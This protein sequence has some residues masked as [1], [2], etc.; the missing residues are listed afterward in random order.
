MKVR[1]RWPRFPLGE[2]RRVYGYFGGHLRE[3]R[4]A[5]LGGAACLMGIALVEM[6][7]PW[8]LKL[9]FDH[10]L[11]PQQAHVGWGGTALRD[12]ST[13]QILILAS[14]GLLAIAVISGLLTYGQ[15]MLLGAVGHRVV[16][17]IRLQLFSHIQRLPQSYHDQRE[18]GDLM[19]RLTG[20]LNLLKDLLVSIVIT[21]GSRIV[22][23]VGMLVAMLWM[24]WQ[25]TLI[26]LSI[27]PVLLAA[28]THFS[29]RIKSESRR[30]RRKEGMLADAV[31]QSFAGMTL[32][33]VFAQEKRQEKRFSKGIS[34]DV[35]A[36]LKI[37]RLEASFSRTVEI[38]TALGLCLV[39]WF[40]VRRV[41]AQELSAGD[42]LIFMSY[43]RQLYRPVRDTARLATRTSKAIVAA[44]RVMEVLDLKAPIEDHPG[45]VSA[46]G[47]QGATRFEGVT[48]AYSAGNPVLH[49]VSFAIPAGKT[50][51]IIGPSGS[52]KSTI[53]KL[54]LRLYEPQTGRILIDERDY[55]EYQLHSF[56]KQITSLTQDVTMF[57]ASVR[58]NIAFSWPKATDDQ[59]V[60]AAQSVGAHQFIMD[61]PNGYDTVLG[62]GGLT[63][64]GGQR[65]RLA[66]ARAALRDSRI[67]IFDEPATGLDADA[68]R[69]AKQALL[70]LRNGRTLVI[71]THRLNFLE[72]ADHVIVVEDGRVTDEGDPV[73]LS[74]KP[75]RFQAFVQ[76]WYDAQHPR[77]TSDYPAV[78]PV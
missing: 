34:S 24:D 70:S 59:I 68:E 14:I 27:V 1:L 73:D 63:L 9:V 21:L 42:L 29:T 13:T 49:N 56:R 53:A 67:M 31:H 40:G 7:R 30:Q 51:A 16:G 43:I 35:R 26:A 33:K 65:Q 52:G 66:F 44:Q 46:F 38:V 5:L 64:S 72:L 55:R 15:T 3:H 58:D 41:L 61:L 12:W 54:L 47:L 6:A 8:P 4:P 76:N 78:N 36:G 71:I 74:G 62:E 11:L 57:H 50:T 32:T 2:L 45:A 22:I 77:H 48:F 10:I 17:G 18:T 75:G 28:N 60:A 69:H 37:R 23:V 25:L 19:M 39:L 20:D